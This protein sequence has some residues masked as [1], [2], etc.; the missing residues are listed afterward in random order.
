LD[1]EELQFEFDRP[2][3][4]VD[5]EDDSVLLAEPE[6]IREQYLAAVNEYLV[7]MHEG[8][9]KFQADYRRVS[10]DASYEQVIADFLEE[11]EMHAKG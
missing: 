2:M 6:V 7:K 1:P 3:R 4:F 10:T 11:R 8:C 5:L 9:N